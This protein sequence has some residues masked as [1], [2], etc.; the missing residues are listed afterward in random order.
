M[1]LKNLTKSYLVGE[2]KLPVFNDFSLDIPQRGITAFLG[3]SGC[4]KTTLLRVIGSLEQL[5]GGEIVKEESE[6]GA[7]SYLFQEPRLLPWDSV[8]TN[9]EIVLRP[10]ISNRSE[11]IE[12]AMKFIELVG[13]KEYF[14]FKPT[15][16]S[17]GMKQR[18][19]IARAFAFPA[20]VMLLDEPFQSLDSTLR[21]ALI[22]SY[23]KLWE[24]ERRTTLYV[25][26]DLQE[27]Y[28][29]ADT[30][31]KLSERP[32]KVAKT[33][34]ITTPRAKRSPNDSAFLELLT[35]FYH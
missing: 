18:V 10:S 5:D 7:V 1:R 23:L 11:R 32:M 4:G 29:V 6:L 19:A 12:S 3:P 30:L 21:S 9:V 34:P 31:I 35:Q 27:A 15:Q 16:L 8:L 28:L 13:L 24:Q 14:R 26:H 22:D 33:I 25:T 17:G 20:N 2:E